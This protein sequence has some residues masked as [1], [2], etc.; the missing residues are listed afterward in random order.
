MYVSGI[1]FTDWEVCRYHLTH[2]VIVKSRKHE[3]AMFPVSLSWNS[4]RELAGKLDAFCS[5][6]SWLLLLVIASFVSCLCHQRR[7]HWYSL[8]FPIVHWNTSVTL[9]SVIFFCC[10][11]GLFLSA[12]KGP[13]FQPL[14]PYLNLQH[15]FP[16]PPLPFHCLLSSLSLSRVL[17]TKGWTY[18]VASTELLWCYTSLS[19]H[20]CKGILVVIISS[21]CCIERA[22]LVLPL[23]RHCK[24]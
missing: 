6:T 7:H 15:P 18:K 10:L 22:H 4:L 3:T 1:N 14:L 8:C 20:Q 13:N 16:I 11:W 19:C 23:Q 17:Q 5:F 9:L 21:A 24:S 2:V 12:E